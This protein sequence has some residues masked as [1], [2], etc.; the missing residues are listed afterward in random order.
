M[1]KIFKKD[2]KILIVEIIACVCLAV[3]GYFIGNFMA[4][5]QQEQLPQR[6]EAVLTEADSQDEENSKT[7]IQ[8]VRMAQLVEYEI[9]GMDDYEIFMV[10]KTNDGAIVR[11]IINQPLAEALTEHYK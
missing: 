2:V 10:V 9:E 3:L 4:E 6:I 1:D 8:E 5:R 7:T 11:T